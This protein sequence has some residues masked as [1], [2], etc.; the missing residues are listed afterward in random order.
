MNLT[1]RR[2]LISKLSIVG[3]MISQRWVGS[4]PNLGHQRANQSAILFCLTLR[5]WQTRQINAERCGRLQR[6]IATSG[7]SA[8]TRDL[9]LKHTNMK[10]PK[11]L[12]TMKNYGATYQRMT[13]QIG[14]KE[15]MNKS[16]R[17]K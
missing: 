9:E 6:V 1:L 12:L 11:D 3:R 14:K 16:G 5:C 8:R 10:C 2:A 4:L 7:F 15:I 17:S 13:M